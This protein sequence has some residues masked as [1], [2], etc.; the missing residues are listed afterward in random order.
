MGVSN[1][2]VNVYIA[3]H[4]YARVCNVKHGSILDANLTLLLFYSS[5]LSMERGDGFQ[6]PIIITNPENDDEKELEEM[7]DE[8]AVVFLQDWYHLDGRTRR[9]GKLIHYSLV[10]WNWLH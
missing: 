4:I 8:E 9:A 3:C 2:K 5:D 6:G 7:Y 1:I 10:P